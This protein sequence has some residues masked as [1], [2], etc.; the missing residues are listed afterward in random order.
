ML[1]N[2]DVTLVFALDRC[3]NS[4]LVLS[5]RVIITGRLMIERGLVIE[6][7]SSTVLNVILV[8]YKLLYHES[9]STKLDYISF[10][11]PECVQ[12]IRLVLLVF[13]NAPDPI[14]M[15]LE[16]VILEALAMVHPILPLLVSQTD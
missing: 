5:C 1:P 3:H 15:I 14:S 10:Y 8:D 16:A 12:F 6:L 11:Y 2:V 9:H 13:H 4:Q 7:I